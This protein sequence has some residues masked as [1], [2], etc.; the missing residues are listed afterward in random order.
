[1]P[2]CLA[3]SPFRTLATCMQR[4]L[5]STSSQAQTGVRF[6]GTYVGNGAYVSHKKGISQL[7]MVSVR[8]ECYF[9]RTLGWLGCRDD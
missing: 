9:R 8:P 1:M 2:T 5:F 4:K 6:Y 3:S 7:T